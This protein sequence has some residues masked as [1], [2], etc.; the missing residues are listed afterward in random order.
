MHSRLKLTVSMDDE[1]KDEDE[2]EEA[3][4]SNQYSLEKMKNVFKRLIKPDNIFSTYKSLETQD[5][6]FKFFNLET[7]SD[8]PSPILKKIKE[9]REKIIQ[10]NSSSRESGLNKKDTK[11]IYSSDEYEFAVNTPSYSYVEQEEKES[12]S[13]Y[14]IYAINTGAFDEDDLT[15]TT[16]KNCLVFLSVINELMNGELNYHKKSY[17]IVSRYNTI[18]KMINFIKSNGQPPTPIRFDGDLKQSF[19]QT[20]L[21][22]KSLPKSSSSKYVDYK[23]IIPEIR[24]T[25]MDLK[26]FY[27]D[28][29]RIYYYVKMSKVPNT[30]RTKI[31]SIKKCKELKPLIS[32]ID[33][34]LIS[35]GISHND[36]STKGNVFVDVDNKYIYIIDFGTA[37]DLVYNAGAKANVSSNINSLNIDCDKE[38]ES[39]E[40]K[41]GVSKKSSVKRNTKKKHTKVVSAKSLSKMRFKSTKKNKGRRNKTK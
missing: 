19:E 25:N 22:I 41:K 32:V 40:E 38:L 30:D 11:T 13:F 12:E 21:K 31:Q 36:Y 14:K 37:G 16:D 8:N 6:K 10:Y 18:D 4:D 9:I 24:E 28:K 2:V 34:F 39:T 17:D 20:K 26:E 5:G 35:N 23:V 7:H 27:Y 1:N 3:S 15:V 29:S 33:T